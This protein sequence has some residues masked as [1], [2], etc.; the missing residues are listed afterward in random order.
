LKLAAPVQGAGENRVV[1]VDP[2]TG[3]SIALRGFE[4]SLARMLN[5]R[6]TAAAVVEAATAIGMPISLEAL[7][8]FVRQLG[9]AGFL[10]R[11]TDAPIQTPT[12]WNQRREWDDHHRSRYQQALKEAR[13]DQLPAAKQHLEDLQHDAFDNTDVKELHAWVDQRMK[14]PADGKALP[15]FA[16]IFSTVE[17]SW[18][19][20]GE[21]ASHENEHS[22]SSHADH[23]HAAAFAPR[24]ARVPWK[25]I[26]VVA[27]TAVIVAIA[28]VPW[29]VKQ[30]GSFELTARNTVEV[31]SSKPGMVGSLATSEGE[32][33][34]AG[35]TLFSY[36]TH[37]AQQKLADAQQQ[38]AKL[39]RELDELTAHTAVATT[40]LATAQADLQAAQAELDQ[41]TRDHNR[42]AIVKA[43]KHVKSADAKAKQATAA[44]N[45]ATAAAAA[46][47]GHSQADLVG[48]LKDATAERDA[49]QALSE[50]PP[51]AAPA[52][53]FVVGLK[54]KLG[55]HIAV[56]APVCQ[57]AD[58]KV[59]V[60]KMRVGEGETMTVGQTA[61]LTV[62]G[63]AFEVKIDKIEGGEGL[64]VLDNA[65]GAI[66][67]GT[68]GDLRVA[69]GSKSLL[70][71]LF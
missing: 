59:L 16:E 62:D 35:A 63:K 71:R 7:D 4:L 57:V 37:V 39:Q 26:A 67:A 9:T 30:Q 47:A 29:P 54:V 36:D 25:W 60:V 15:T 10:A 56:G 41:A 13:S 17:R 55:D 24:R 40:Q 34:D 44:A 45:K 11:P 23:A 65:T 61:S 42:K 46:A 28:L 48:K 53:G 12:T 2:T 64:G 69:A 1:V 3:T 22:V 8:R 5:G 66:K 21:R 19:E 31:T 6:R 50:L 20:E 49:Q 52:A 27:V 33:V 38:I 32:W 43:N 14:M 70:G 58:T 68:R 18:F 51:L